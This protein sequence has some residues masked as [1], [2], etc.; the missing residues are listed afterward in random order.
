MFEQ[1]NNSIMCG[2]EPM[3]LNLDI[4][5]LIFLILVIFE[6]GFL[7]GRQWQLKWVVR[8]LMGNRFVSLPAP[9]ETDSKKTSLISQDSTASQCLSMVAD[10]QQL[11]PQNVEN[12]FFQEKLPFQA[13]KRSNTANFQLILEK[14]GSSLIKVE[15]YEQVSEFESSSSLATFEFN[16]LK[17]TMKR[18]SETDTEGDKNGI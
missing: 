9:A 4:L 6:I 5:S 2:N 16:K 12:L 15:K 8:I 14:R 18:M 17:Q 1:V 3:T 7:V 13:P 10:K 11:D